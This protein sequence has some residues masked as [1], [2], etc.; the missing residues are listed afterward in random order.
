MHWATV[1]AL[2]FMRAL[3]VFMVLVVATKGKIL[4]DE[5]EPT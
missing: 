5:D 3:A 4:D 2:D 1:M